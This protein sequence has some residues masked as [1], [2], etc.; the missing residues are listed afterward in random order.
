MAMEQQTVYFKSNFFSS[1]MTDIVDGEERVIGQLDLNSMFNS[2]IHVMNAA[3][4]TLASGK[5]PFFSNKWEVSNEYGSAIGRVYSRFSIFS[6]KF[7]YESNSQGNYEIRAEA[8]SKEY[9]VT[10]SSGKDAANFRKINGLFQSGAYQLNNMSELPT[11][12][13]IAVVMGIHAIQERRS[14][15]AN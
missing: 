7:E 12:E 8:F 5:F 3:G 1:G 14:Q 15:S 2:G 11:A 4:E 13:W 6:K 9:D 10:D